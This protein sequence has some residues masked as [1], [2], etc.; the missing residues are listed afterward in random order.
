MNLWFMYCLEINVLCI[1]Y[2]F[3]FYVFIDVPR[4]PYIVGLV[5][6]WVIEKAKLM[7]S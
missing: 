2:K 5:Q 1:V 6:V 4:L 3:T 7:L